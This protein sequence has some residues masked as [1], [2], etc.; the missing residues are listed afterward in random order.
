MNTKNLIIGLILAV[1]VAAGG[2]WLWQ[3]QAQAA[4]GS[5]PLE[6]TGVIEAR[7][8]SLAPEVGGRVVEVLVEEGER[9]TAGQPLARL[10]ETLLKIQ[11]AQAQANL[12][13]LIAGPTAEQLSAA[14]AQLAQAEANLRLAQ[15]AF[16]QTTG[17]SRPEEISA[18]RAS[19]E[20]A[21]ANYFEMRVSLTSEQMEEIRSA[22]TTAEG[23]LKNA[24]SRRDD[25][26]KDSKNPEFTVA[27]AQAAVSEAQAVL[28]AVQ[29]AYDLASD[30]D[31]PYYLQIEAARLSLEL[32]QS[33]LNQAKAR[34]EAL[35]DDEATTSAAQK[36]AEAA[37]DDAQDMLDAAESAYQALTSGVST[38]R[39]IA[40]WE[41][42][43]RMQ[44][45]LAAFGLSVPGSPSVETL[46]AQVDA[47]SAARDMAAANLAALQ[48]GT[49]QEQIN[50]AQAQ[51]D[52]LDAQLEKL[53]LLA[54]W[55]GVVL[56]RSTEPGQIALPGGTLLE[57]GRLDRLEL[58]VYLP[59]EKFGVITPGQAVRVYV[60]A[61]PDRTFNGVVMRLA[62]E[63]EFTPTNVQTKED[64]TRLVYAVVIGL[65]NPDLA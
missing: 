44:T 1:V 18:T 4:S 45:Q 50:A 65:D 41:E 55:D 28:A 6:A 9:V 60:D 49:R 15:S 46:L 5:E 26:A 38:K 33:N 42:V 35:A 51:V 11:R 54:P 58:T 19:L 56:T 53:T 17:R 57:I 7:T 14:Q 39:L 32:A 64:R 24:Q 22:V 2:F 63:A 59:E 3:S 30:A 37:V 62:D 20:Q 43:Q 25:L 12:N 31:Q 47:A 61:Y 16:D 27:A 23:N 10:D 48:A 8:V 34:R 21:R 40:V 36:A 13:M 29:K 52:A